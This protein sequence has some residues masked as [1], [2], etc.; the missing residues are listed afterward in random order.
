[1]TR[2]T[3]KDE[4]YLCLSGAIQIPMSRSE[5]RKL[6]KTH[7]GEDFGYNVEAWKTYIETQ[8]GF[9]QHAEQLHALRIEMTANR[10]PLPLPLRVIYWSLPWNWNPYEKTPWWKPWTWF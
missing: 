9:D 1:M 5:C 8:G 7:F 3:L 4:I 2:L 10:K 6:L